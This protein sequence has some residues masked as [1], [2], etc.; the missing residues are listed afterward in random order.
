MLTTKV[1]MAKYTHIS[2]KG[3]VSDDVVRFT[4]RERERERDSDS[5]YLSP[6]SLSGS[7]EQVRSTK[8]M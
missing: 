2:S 1:N 4:A 8:L 7:E 6:E 5:P 3:D